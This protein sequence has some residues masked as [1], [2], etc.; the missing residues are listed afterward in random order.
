MAD[1]TDVDVC[2]IANDLMA[3]LNLDQSELSTVQSLVTT[4]KEVVS[5]SA[6]GSN[7]QL[8]IP[9]IKTLATAQYY[10]RTL[11]NGMPNGLLMMLTHIQAASSG[12]SNGN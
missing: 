9:A 10:D 7:D 5:R 6:D 2:K 11:S 4:A 12:D 8:V 1:S 3:E